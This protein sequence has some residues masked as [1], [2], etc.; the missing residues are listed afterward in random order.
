MAKN[1]RY[2]SAK[3]CIS[4]KKWFEPFSQLLA[5]FNNYICN[6]VTDL[7]TAYMVRELVFCRDNNIPFLLTN[8]EMSQLIEHICTI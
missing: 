6:E 8:T 5:C 3:Y 1:Y 4:I 2:L 7:D